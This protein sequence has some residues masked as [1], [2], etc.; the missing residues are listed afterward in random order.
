MYSTFSSQNLQNLRRLKTNF[1]LKP[2]FFPS[3]APRP[4]PRLSSIVGSPISIAISIAISIPVS[5]PIVHVASRHSRGLRL[6]EA[7][8]LAHFLRRGARVLPDG[9]PLQDVFVNPEASLELGDDGGLGEI[10]E[11]D[12]GAFPE[13]LDPVREALLSP[14]LGLDHRGLVL[15]DHALEHL[16]EGLGVLIREARLDDEYRLVL[17]HSLSSWLRAPR[18]LRGA[19][20]RPDSGLSPALVPSS[21]ESIHSLF[22]S[23]PQQDFDRL[24]R[25]SDHRADGLDLARAETLQNVPGE[26]SLFARGS[27]DA[28]PYPRDGLRPQCLDDGC[29]PVVS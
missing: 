25:F 29:H 28:D 13:V 19:R 15:G 2:P 21:V 24:R 1:F 26:T 23:V 3:L 8:R 4:F 11:E 14:P 7:G 12:V 20:R 27:S 18:T 16:G 9:D 6:R 17:V 22:H 10:L 5:V